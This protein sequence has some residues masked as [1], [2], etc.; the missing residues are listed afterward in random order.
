MYSVG[1]TVLYGSNGVCNIEEIT[2]KEI[3]GMSI[4]YYV[5]KPL[6]SQNS[7]LFVPVNNEKLVS[8]I[9]NVLS[10]DEINSILN[11]ISECDEWID[12][13]IERIDLFKNII[14]SGDCSQLIK[15]IR[16][17]H[18]HEQLQISRGK[19]L[20]IS[21]EKCLR[22]AEKMVCDEISL[23][24]GIDRNSALDLVLSNREH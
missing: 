9:R 19:R 10:S 7:T 14:S 21:D 4:D 24:L 12:N 6:Y 8:K 18:S 1:Q 23:V 15:L 3:S 20:H 22:E 17:I 11:N 16:L 5:L 13:K 2:T